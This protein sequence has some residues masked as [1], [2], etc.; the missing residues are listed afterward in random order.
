MSDVMIDDDTDVAV[1]ERVRMDPPRLWNVI[2]LN[3]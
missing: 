3:Y 1:I 2:F